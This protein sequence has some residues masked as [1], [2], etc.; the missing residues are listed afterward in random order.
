ML[1]S[2]RCEDS[3]DPGYGIKIMVLAA[4]LTESVAPQQAASLLEE[5]A[6]DL[7]ALPRQTASGLS[8]VE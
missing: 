7:A 4:T 3:I 8:V 6:P 5:P 1:E 2:L